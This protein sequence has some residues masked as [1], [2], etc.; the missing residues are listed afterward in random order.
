VRL[1]GSHA[2]TGNEKAES[3]PDQK[4][5]RL[6]AAREALEEPG[7]SNDWTTKPPAKA[8]RLNSAACR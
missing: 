1:R 7:R 4:K 2:A 5:N 3:P 8:S 6:A